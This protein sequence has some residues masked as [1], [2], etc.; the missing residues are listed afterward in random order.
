MGDRGGPNGVDRRD[1]SDRRDGGGY[2]GPR[3]QQQRGQGQRGI[4]CD[5]TVA[6][7]EPVTVFICAVLMPIV[8]AVTLPFSFV[9]R[10]FAGY[11]YGDQDGRGGG[12]GGWEE[13]NQNQM[14][15]QWDEYEVREA[16]IFYYAPLICI[17]SA[18]PSP[19]CPCCTCIRMSYLQSH[20]LPI[21]MAP[22]TVK[23]SHLPPLPLGAAGGSGTGRPARGSKQ[24]RR[25]GSE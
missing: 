17:P 25:Q 13:D 11:G 15:G 5:L 18:F 6:I 9:Y 16:L 20:A 21:P 8:T 3:F 1:Q 10:V 24:E 23:L 12:G 2:G 4:D 14:Q 22:L 7:G 19:E